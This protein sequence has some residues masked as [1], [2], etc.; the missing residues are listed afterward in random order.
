MK[1]LLSKSADRTYSLRAYIK[2]KGENLLQSII[3]IKTK[4]KE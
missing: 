3:V 4:I 2:V 1:C